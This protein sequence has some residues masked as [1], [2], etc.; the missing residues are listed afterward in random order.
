MLLTHVIEKLLDL[1]ITTG[2]LCRAKEAHFVEIVSRSISLLIF[3]NY[4]QAHVIQMLSQLTIFWDCVAKK[5]VKLR[6]ED[7]IVA[8][9]SF[10]Y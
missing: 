2:E 10:H 6:F 4:V 5:V 1:V 8:R 7:V 3:K 9:V